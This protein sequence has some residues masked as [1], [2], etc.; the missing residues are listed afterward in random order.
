VKEKITKSEG[1]EGP[2]IDYYTKHYEDHYKEHLAG[3]KHGNVESYPEEDKNAMKEGYKKA[4]SPVSLYTEEDNGKFYTPEDV[5]KLS[6]NELKALHENVEGQVHDLIGSYEY[7]KASMLAAWHTAHVEPELA[8]RE[9]AKKETTKN[10]DHFVDG[11]G[12]KKMEVA[13]SKASKT[14]HTFVSAFKHR[15]DMDRAAFLDLAK[16]EMPMP[17]PMTF[18]GE[19]VTPDDVSKMKD[20]ELAELH[21]KFDSATRQYFDLALSSNNPSGVD[22][23][24]AAS[25]AAWHAQVIGPEMDARAEAWKKGKGKKQKKAAQTPAPAGQASEAL[26]E[27]EGEKQKGAKYGSMDDA[28][29]KK[30]ATTEKAAKTPLPKSLDGLTAK[31]GTQAGSNPGGI[32]HAPD[33]T[34]YYVKTPQSDDHAHNESIAASLYDSMGVNVPQVGTVQNKDGKHAV[35]SKMV[36]G[37]KRVGDPSTAKKAKGTHEGFAADA[38]LAN[39]DVVGAGHDNLHVD[40]DGNALRVD[41]GGALL[42][43]AQGKPKGHAFGSQV[44]EIDSLRKGSNPQAS[45]VFGSMSDKDV[46]HSFMG[47]V[48]KMSDQAIEHVVHAHEGMGVGT[49]D[50]LV[51]TLKERRDYMAEWAKK[52]GA[53]IDKNSDGTW[54]VKGEELFKTNAGQKNAFK[55]KFGKKGVDDQGNPRLGTL[56]HPKHMKA[57]LE[58]KIKPKSF[59]IGDVPVTVGADHP[60]A[61][62]TQQFSDKSAYPNKMSEAIDKALSGQK[63]DG[64]HYNDAWSLVKA[65]TGSEYSSMNDA[66]RGNEGHS[67][68]YKK[69]GLAMDAL[70]AKHGKLP[71]PVML[72]R[73][74]KMHAQPH[75][76]KPNEGHQNV[77]YYMRV[78]ER[79]IR[80]GGSIQLKGMQSATRSVSTARSFSDDHG[81]MF[82]ITAKEGL[83]VRHISSHK[84]EDEIVL[85]HNR[86][87]R[88]KGIHISAKISVSGNDRRH[89]IELEQ[90]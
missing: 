28:L 57:V 59:K 43:R 20:H 74:I 8:K 49:R 46:V 44:T 86:R 67:E 73:G 12:L 41:T 42:Y 47:T 22:M 72:L 35:I 76:D 19:D 75:S 81:F 77:N 66:L 29:G 37:A 52:K 84:S 51:K 50:N 11:P 26:P 13:A 88:V 15:F 48:A 87:Y 33:G 54:S 83:P 16:N 79:A 69:A 30:A 70:I 80:N 40:K 78:F 63:I 89:I 39:W 18:H 85:G 53:K 24:L 3:Y 21:D 56:V 27:A 2:G 14:P 31:E 38:W 62:I 5:K 60:W 4:E 36:D 58:G 68:S 7:N 82:K 64:G 9:K 45:G 10:A 65:Y 61:T 1:G 55:S 17:A 90:V 23:G 71:H 25:L 32:H 6:D 34:A